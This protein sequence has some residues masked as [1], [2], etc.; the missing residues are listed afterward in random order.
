[1]SIVKKMCV[2]LEKVDTTCLW[3]CR[4]WGYLYLILTFGGAKGS[5][6]CS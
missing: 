1:M 6:K 2:R 4:L 5:K 3:N